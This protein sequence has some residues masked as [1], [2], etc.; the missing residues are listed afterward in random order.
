VPHSPAYEASTDERFQRLLAAAREARTHAYVPYSRFAVG[1]ALLTESGETFTGCNVENASYSLTLCAERVAVGKAISA[2]HRVI[3]A[4]AVVGPE[5]DIPCSPCG[6]CRQVLHEFGPE[7][8]VVTGSAAAPE[9]SRMSELLPAAF[10]P[11]NLPRR[12]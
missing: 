10:G 3:R 8:V 1:A 9:V 2:G 4:I 6:S 5:D 12:G 7:M 11:A